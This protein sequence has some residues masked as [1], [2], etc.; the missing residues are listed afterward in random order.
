MGDSGSP[1]RAL[2][3]MPLGE[4][5]GGAEQQLQ[6]LIAHRIEANLDPIVAFLETGP[7]V[8]WCLEQGVGSVVIDAGRARHI[9]VFGRTVRAVAKLAREGSAEVIVG[10]M[11]KGQLYGGLAAVVAGLPSLWLQPAGPSGFAPFDRAATML[12]AKLV[13]TV[14][15]ETDVAQRRLRPGRMT[16]VI[17]PAVDTARFDARR[18]GDVHV[19]RRRLGLPEDGPVFGSVGRLNSWKGFHILL[20]AVP[21]VLAH[22]PYATFVL[23]GGDHALE[24]GYAEQLRAQAESLGRNGQVRLVG[25]QPNPEEWM[26]AMDV[27][28][29]TS[30]R[31]PFGMVVI[32]AMALGKAVVA[33]AEGGPTEIITPEVDGMLCPFGDRRAL[34]SVILRLLEDQQLRRRV[35][36]GARRRAG[37]FSVQTFA[38]RFGDAVRSSVRS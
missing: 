11:A 16:Q 33:T 13:I 6:Q 37:E 10:W 2:I 31:E 23:V 18:V 7:L 9:G 29:H 3:V 34:E 4:Q 1:L 38:Q 36:S 15:R 35:G 24:P 30:R 17:Y 27:F 8:D 21:E 26:Q 19:V 25:Q 12:P 14:S 28:V 22:H 20:D 32:E 5:R